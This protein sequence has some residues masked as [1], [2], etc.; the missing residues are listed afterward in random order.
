MMYSKAF[1]IHDVKPSSF[2]VY[3]TDMDSLEII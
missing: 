2:M 3:I 1:L